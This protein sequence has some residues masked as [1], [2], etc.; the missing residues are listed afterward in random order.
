MKREGT[1]GMDRI[2]RFSAFQRAFHWTYAGA[3]LV[4]LGTGLTFFV[5]ALAPW[6]GPATRLVHRI[7]ALV[8]I[9]AGLSYPLFAR[10]EFLTDLH[11]MF[12]WPPADR[13][14]MVAGPA[15]Y[16][17]ARGHLPP[18]GRYNAGQKLNLWIQMGAFVLFTV[19]GLVMWFGRG[20]V[21]PEL[22]RWMVIGHDVGLIA[23]GGMFVLH[24][25]LSVLHPYTRRSLEAMK[26]GSVSLAY[27]AEEHPLW[28]EEMGIGPRAAGDRPGRKRGGPAGHR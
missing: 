20:A 14:W 25:Y 5:P 26:T 10:K 8:L 12:H 3:F 6:N 15:F 18:Q 17:T 23:A 19:T 24:F 13:R 11:Q 2:P 27:A 9:A 16:T 7:A 28:L 21:S 22:F 1:G 4:L